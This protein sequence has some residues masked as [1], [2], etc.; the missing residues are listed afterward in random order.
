MLIKLRL[1]LRNRRGMIAR[2]LRRLPFIVRQRFR[3]RDAEPCRLAVIALS[4][5]SQANS[6]CHLPRRRCP[7]IRRPG[8]R[9]RL[10][11]AQIERAARG[12]GQGQRL[13]ELALRVLAE[14]VE[15]AFC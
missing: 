15:L 7:L 10:S 11:D 2:R 14:L 5:R 8:R 12:A 4:S 6:V 13:A 9:L 1:H 3:G